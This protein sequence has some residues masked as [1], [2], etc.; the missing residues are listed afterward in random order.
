M[1]KTYR[2]YRKHFE[3]IIMKSKRK[4]YSQK[5]LQFQG[6]PKKHGEL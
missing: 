2:N 5:L 6:D 4:H 1:K 3:T